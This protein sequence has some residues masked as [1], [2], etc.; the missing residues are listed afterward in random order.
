[1][2]RLKKQKSI[3]KIFV[4]YIATFCI[5]TI[6]QIIIILFL[7]I[8][9]LR[10]GVILPANYYEQIVEKNRNQIMV[11]DEVSEFIPEE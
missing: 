8:M 6:L 7:F 10:S 9:G 3:A 4:M 1:M 2:E 5:V 11:T